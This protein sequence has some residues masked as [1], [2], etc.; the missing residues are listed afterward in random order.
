VP[1]QG[2]VSKISN[3]LL[4]ALAFSDAIRWLLQGNWGQV[5]YDYS[6]GT[7]GN[8]QAGSPPEG[9]QIAVATRAY[10]PV[11]AAFVLY[12]VKKELLRRLPVR[13]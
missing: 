9:F 12:E 8:P 11:A 10:G 6:G 13:G 3:I 5:V 2:T 7:A 1:K 4:L